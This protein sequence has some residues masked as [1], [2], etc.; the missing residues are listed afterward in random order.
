MKKEIDLNPMWVTG[1]SDGEASFSVPISANNLYKTN[2]SIIPRFSI[3]LKDTDLDLLYKIKYFFKDVGKIYIL[4]KKGHAVYTVSKIS[5][6]QTVIIPHFTNYPLLTVKRITFLL[7]KEI[8]N[9]MYNKKHFD[10]E[11]MNT[12]II[13]K[14]FMNKNIC[15]TTAKDILSF[16]KDILNQISPLNVNNINF[17][18]LAGFTDAEGCF[19]LNIRIK[20]IIPVFSLVQHSR[21]I[22]LFNLIKDFLG[23]GFIVE[24]RNKNVIRYRSEKLSF[25][26][27]I[28][29]PLFYSHS[30]QSKK[31]L[32]FIDFSLACKLLN[33]KAHLTD[34]GLL[35]I[36]SIKSNMNSNR[37]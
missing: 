21:D 29:I 13:N 31:V 22:I 5:D 9:L 10:I 28:I 23:G 26:I 19:F 3:E 15:K 24:E 16:P 1:F 25:I 37:K 4:E 7:F 11:Y 2:Y 18:W 20:N 27:N 34:E 36:K 6:L 8:I 17:N 33:S 14:S 32:D 35:N 30:L 12:I